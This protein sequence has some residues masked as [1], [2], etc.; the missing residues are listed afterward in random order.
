MTNPEDKTKQD[1]EAFKKVLIPKLVYSW[2][3]NNYG[4]LG[5][6][7]TPKP[8]ILPKLAPTEQDDIL[9]MSIKQIVTGAGNTFILTDLG[10]VYGNGL[11]NIRQKAGG[12]FLS[13]RLRKLML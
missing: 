10:V 5:R 9:A 7:R 1:E 12:E 3:Q 13:H 6:A 4:Q 11:N 2:G 8:V